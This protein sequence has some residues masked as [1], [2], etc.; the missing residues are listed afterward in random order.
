MEYTSHY[1][2]LNKEVLDFFSSFKE[3]ENPLFVDLTFGGGGH[4]FKILEEFPNSKV[5]AFDQDIEALNNG[6]EN[7]EKYGFT[8]R[9][10]F[11]YSNFQNFEESVAQKYEN[12]FSENSFVGCVAD[13][14]VSSHH[15]DEA[16]RGFSFR[17][18]GPLDMRMNIESDGLKAS[19]VIN[20]FSEEDIAEIIWDFG[21]E[22]F[23]RQIAKNIIS[24]RESA[25]I[26]TT[27]QLEDIIFHSYPKKLR[28]DGM[29][30]S[31]KTFQ[32]LRIYV[33]NELGVLTDVIPQVIPRLSL[34]G[35]M[36]I[37]TFHSLEDRIVKHQ[38][39]DFSKN[40]ELPC[41]LLT[42]K[43][44]VPSEEEI[45]E[46]IRSRSAK[47]RVVERVESL[48]SKNKYKNS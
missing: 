16:K 34:G 46:N 7:S 35:K 31:T 2:V 13:L 11:E 18:D 45:I 29:N 5:I 37:I 3:I 24:K 41:S 10:F 40:S 48:P 47:L 8:D 4:T 20:D 6:R 22:R 21:E 42:K 43:P 14:G 17:F 32:A 44:I 30:P 19:D 26:E 36:A 15:F 38:F 39:K 27:K 23:S 28:H 1:S 12:L 25:P 33:N 9:L